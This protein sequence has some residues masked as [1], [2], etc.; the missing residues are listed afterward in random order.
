MG[1]VWKPKI[2]GW[3]KDPGIQLQRTY[4]LNEL[5]RGGLNAEQAYRRAASEQIGQNVQ[6]SQD[7]ARRG[8][9]A[10]FGMGNPSGMVGRLQSAAQLSAPYASAEL[11][12]RE[13]GRGAM[14]NTGQ[15]YQ[16]MK[17]AQANWYATGIGPWL[18]YQQIKNAAAF[19]LG[20]GAGGGGGG[21]MS[22]LGPALGGFA[23]S[24]GIF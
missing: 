9:A 3:T 18:Q 11:N 4:M 22:A 19:G 10:A 20:A 6:A 2:G 17:Q 12:A 8:G 13:A 24:S 16:N 1:E 23:A 7:A 15:A 14:L 5:G 21:I